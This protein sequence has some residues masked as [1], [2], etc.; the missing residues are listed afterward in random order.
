MPLVPI[1]GERWTR[2]EDTSYEI[3]LR[4]DT[5]TGTARAPRYDSVTGLDR[6]DWLPVMFQA[7]YPMPHVQCLH[8]TDRF[9]LR[10][11]ESVRLFT[12]EESPRLWRPGD[13]DQFA[14]ADPEEYLP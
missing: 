4:P 7:T 14:R 11:V 2:L 3:W 1:F 5:L 9:W 8:P 13:T 12:P 10:P 6:T